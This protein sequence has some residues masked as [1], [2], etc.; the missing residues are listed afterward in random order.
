MMGNVLGAHTLYTSLQRGRS[1]SALTCSQYTEQDSVHV[2]TVSC[3]RCLCCK[4]TGLEQE[5]RQ[6]NQI[7]TKRNKETSRVADGVRQ[8][9]VRPVSYAGTIKAADPLL[10]AYSRRL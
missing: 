7:N 8:S 1:H 3:A 5:Q 2:Q 10:C 9:A 4:V 6:K